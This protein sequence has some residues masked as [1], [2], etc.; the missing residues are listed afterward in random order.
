MKYMFLYQYM[1]YLAMLLVLG[2]GK[3]N[4][5]SSADEPK[6]TKPSHLLQK[7]GMDLKVLVTS[8]TIP[9]PHS[10]ISLSRSIS[11]VMP[12]Y[13]WRGVTDSNGVAK[14]EMEANEQDPFWRN[15][16]SGYYSARLT[17]LQ[18]QEVLNQWNSIPIN[19]GERDTLIL[20]I[21]G[22]AFRVTPK[23]AQ[24]LSAP[25]LLEMNGQSYFI[26]PDVAL[27]V[28]RRSAGLYVSIRLSNI[29]N[30]SFPSGVKVKKIWIIHGGEIRE[31]ILRTR[32]APNRQQDTLG[33]HEVRVVAD[34]NPVGE[35]GRR[36]DAVVEI[37]DM[38][39]NLY[40]LKASEQ[41]SQTGLKIRATAFL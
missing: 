35:I 38:N 26:I 19:G 2:C 5:L 16:I 27:F 6:L 29:E 33:L 25:E 20:P 28:P 12:A 15:G 41:R 11:G 37:E 22:K 3:E 39:G 34:G 14:I 31:A 21:G 17:D 10:E 8:N 30:A 4:A 13:H 9:Q 1:I 36:F 7:M 32:Y 24:L 23:L 40:L 18:T